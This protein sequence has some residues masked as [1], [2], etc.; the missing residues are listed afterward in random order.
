M[1]PAGEA[2]GQERAHAGC[3]VSARPTV[4]DALF[5]A[6]LPLLAVGPRL[7]GLGFYSDDWAFLESLEEAGSFLA[8]ARTFLPYHAMRPVFGVYLSGL[9][10]LFQAC[11]L[12]G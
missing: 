8:G 1:P 4:P 11:R 6:L 7:L 5:L 3:I 9:H 2:D 10:W 12:P